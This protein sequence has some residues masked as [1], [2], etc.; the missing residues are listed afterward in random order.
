MAHYAKIENN[1]VTSVLVI[2]NEDEN[3][4]GEAGIELKL[5][6]QGGIWK[7]TSYN[8]NIRKNYAGVGYTFD[9]VR[10]AFIS[11]KP[12]PSWTLIEATCQWE[13]STPYPNDGLRYI[14]DEATLNWVLE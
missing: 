13:T 3:S 11:P 1:I 6:T 7:K 12:Y 10:D 5:N 8:N 4:L 2:S 9:S 14:W